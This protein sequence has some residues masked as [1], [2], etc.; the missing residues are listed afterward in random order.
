MCT[1][2]NYVADCDY[3]GRN[4]DWTHGYVEKIIITPEHFSIMFK[5]HKP[6][7]THYA[8]MGMGIVRD[9]YPLY[10]DC[11]NNEGLCIA[12]LNFP[13]NAVYNEPVSGMD[14]I[15]AY[16]MMLWIL[17]QC[18]ST[19]D[20][21]ALLKN[22][23]II[24]ASFSDDLPVTPMHWIVSDKNKSI[25]IEPVREGVMVYDNPKGVLA[26][27]PPFP[28][29][30]KNSDKDIPYSTSSES[31]FKRAVKIMEEAPCHLVEKDSV[32]M[33]FNMLSQ[34][35]IVKTTENSQYTIYS[36]CIN[37]TKGIYYY[38]LYENEVI[39]KTSFSEFELSGNNVI[40]GNVC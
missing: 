37:A 9:N 3:F 40:H 35:G 30:M 15:A 24:N 22:T 23:N 17:C 12:G 13:D 27:N 25:V 2:L 28:E 7:T 33:F 18:K 20:A 36:S 5:N 21:K 31:R 29:Q 10:F 11:V 38:R 32:N 39:Y 14:N 1:A 34:V 6:I 19:Y 26:N 4:L 16:E 8:V